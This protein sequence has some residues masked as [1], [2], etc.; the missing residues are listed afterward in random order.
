MVAEGKAFQSLQVAEQANFF[1]VHNLSKAGRTIGNQNTTRYGKDSSQYMNESSFQTNLAGQHASH[2]SMMSETLKTQSIEAAQYESY[3][4]PDETLRNYNDPNQTYLLNTP[5]EMDPYGTKKIQIFTKILDVDVLTDTSLIYDPMW[6]LQVLH[7]QNEC[8]PSGSDLQVIEVGQAHTTVVPSSGKMYSFGWNDFFQ[9]GRPTHPE[10]HISPYAQINLPIDNFRPKTIASG[11]DHNLVLDYSGNLYIWGDNSKGQLGLGHCRQ[12]SRI[13]ILDFLSNDALQEV[14]AK[15]NNSLAVTQSGK[16]FAWPVQLSSGEK[17][18]R[19][20][21]LCLPPKIQISTTACGYNFAV[22]VSKNGLAFTFGRDNKLGQLGHGDT[23]PRDTPTLVETLKAEGETVM[24]VSCGYKHVICKTKLGRV[25][26]W[27]WG[28]KG[29]LGH[30]TFENQLRPKLVNFNMNGSKAK[31][32][33]AQAG[34]QHSV[35]VLDNKKVLWWG[36]NASLDCMSVPIEIDMQKK[37]PGY[38][39]DFTP[40]KILCTWSK[41]MNVTYITMADSRTTEFAPS[42][43]QK[44]LST[45]TNK[46]EESCGLNNIDLPF[47][48][49]ISK[50]FSMKVMKNHQT[51]DPKTNRPLSPRK[52]AGVT[53][54]TDRPR[55]YMESLAKLRS[56]SRAR[57]PPPVIE[58]NQSYYSSTQKSLRMSGST[59]SLAIKSPKGLNTSVNLTS[60]LSTL[61]TSQ[62]PKGLSMMRKNERS[63]SRDGQILIQTPPS[64]RS[65]MVGFRASS[66]EK[67]LKKSSPVKGDQLGSLNHKLLEIK[68]KMQEIIETPMEKWS[69]TDAE[70]IKM[71]T[72]P[73]MLELLQNVKV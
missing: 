5:K 62:T 64:G 72:E 61:S 73:E 58:T 53:L 51:K 42:V 10:E 67:E 50:H 13:T 44:I 54:K 65:N 40:V 2:R 11:D 47:V 12:T 56:S 63:R 39:K 21:E 34:Y 48:D 20:A 19:P 36:T 49:S 70:F 8:N 68:K 66:R 23:Q 22:L 7:L 41:T 38:N 43:K 57:D 17:I 55:F 1:G 35:I 16:V 26:S 18:Y 45:L 4:N 37:I 33:Q 24:N 30:G 52:S 9:L 28:K 69:K 60:P 59:K 27:G 25:Y 14:K 6:S 3:I 15:G 31:V 46:I 29:Q 32:L 71:A